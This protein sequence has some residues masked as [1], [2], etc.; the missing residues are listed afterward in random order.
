MDRFG[1]P[2]RPACTSLSDDG[3]PNRCDKPLIYIIYGF[4]LPL[5]AIW[6]G[7]VSPEQKVSRD[8]LGVRTRN[9]QHLRG[10]HLT[11]GALDTPKVGDCLVPG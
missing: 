7:S 2:C 6:G 10:T 3:D 4:A 9:G 8:S 5:G 1:R 11:G